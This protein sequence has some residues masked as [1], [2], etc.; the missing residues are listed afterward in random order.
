MPGWIASARRRLPARGAFGWGRVAVWSVLALLLPA[1]LFVLYALATIPRDGGMAAEAS[2]SAVIVAARDGQAFATRGIVKG[3]KLAAADLPANLK[4]AIVAIEDRRFYR[5]FGVDARS[6]GRAL[7]RNASGGREGASTITQQLAR[8]TYLSQERSLRR[9]VQEALLALWLDATLPKDEILARYLNSAYFG[10]GAY[11][12]DAAARRYFGKP[13]KDLDLP[14]AAMLAGLVR[15]PSAL[16]PHRNLE[17]ARGRA[18]TVLAAMVETGAAKAEEAEAARRNPASV[19]EPPQT[20]P[21]TGYYLDMVEAEARRATG[22]SGADVTVAGTLDLRLQAAAE[23]AVGRILAEEG[24]AKNVT[25]AAL[26]AMAPD[27]AILAMVGGRNYADSQFNRAVQAKRQAGSLFK[28]FVYL[29]AVESGAEPQSVAV[30]A[31]IQIGEWEP[32]NYG[33]RYR[34]VVTLK[35]AFANSINT[36]AVQLADAVGLDRVIA[37]ARALGVASDLPKVPSLA[38]G[39]AEVT[40][41]EM[42]RAYA[43][44]AAGTGPVEPYLIRSVARGGERLAEQ[45]AAPK[46]AAIGAE[47]RDAMVEML[48]AVVREGTGK[49]AR[50]PN[51]LA[52]GKTGTTQES[53]DA[54]FVGFTPAVTI[55]VWV[56][57][58]DNTP[59]KNVTGGDMPARIW[60]AVAAE[61]GRL[62][63]PRAEAAARDV[64]PPP[65]ETG[66]AAP[67]PPVAS[68]AA[69]VRGFASVRD[70]ATLDVEGQ[71]IRLAGIEGLGGRAARDLARYIRRRPVACEPDPETP[72]THRCIVQGQDL[73]RVILFNGGARASPDAPADLREA[74]EQARE[75]GV[76]VWGR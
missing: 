8:L 40:L 71:D 60:R 38:L 62:R 15:A 11:G 34:G 49:S 29:A 14:E 44:V 31:P 39:S 32:E 53:R 74:E 35:A 58:D 63:P 9:K 47:A 55:G 68:P 72:Q 37:T 10:A 5:H 4:A 30:D 27:G 1:L 52:G 12:A 23:R 64:T 66:R 20:P 56:G 7:F 25:Q 28:L 6:I 3:E 73:A 59:T 75:A 36:V 24:R 70:T 48:V 43:A 45:R 21:G 46:P 65:R 19:W 76:G 2:P 57:N 13:A 42:V 51:V 33:G 18:E 61:A 22:A 69:R 17:G 26:V 41:I 50:L 67:T 16:A 54:W